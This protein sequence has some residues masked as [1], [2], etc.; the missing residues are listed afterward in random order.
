[1]NIFLYTEFERQYRLECDTQNASAV[2]G[3]ANEGVDSEKQ[4]PTRLSY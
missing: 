4:R 2:L 3:S 1:M